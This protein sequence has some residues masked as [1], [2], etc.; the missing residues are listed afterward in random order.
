MNLPDM[1]MRA[2]VQGNVELIR[3]LLNGGVSAKCTDTLQ[4]YGMIKYAAAN[5]HIDVMRILLEW[6]AD[7]DARGPGGETAL[8]FACITFELEAVDFLISNN[9]SLVGSTMVPLLKAILDS[10]IPGDVMDESKFK[11][12]VSLLSAGEVIYGPSPYYESALKEVIGRKDGSISHLFQIRLL[13]LFL[14][15][16]V[17]VNEQDEY[18]RTA[19]HHA[20]ILNNLEATVCLL[21]AGVGIFTVDNIGCTA[22]DVFPP[23]GEIYEQRDNDDEQSDNDVEK[24]FRVIL[25]LKE[26]AMRVTDTWKMK[27]FSMGLHRRSVSPIQALSIEHIHHIFN[28]KVPETEHEK[29][30]EKL[31]AVQMVHRD[32]AGGVGVGM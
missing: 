31:V 21:K 7:I 19:L 25:L 28:V 3:R 4:Q 2:A 27:Q 12:V 13:E 32:G 14:K 24:D 6:G 10:C 15:S 26:V 1:M 30:I 18:G 22:E 23:N 17:N 11:V 29:E 20:S 9:A 16:D 5:G 8:F